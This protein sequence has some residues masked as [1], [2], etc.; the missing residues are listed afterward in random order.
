MCIVGQQ[1]VPLA[2]CLKD[3]LDVP[4]GPWLAIQFGSPSLQIANMFVAT[5][6]AHMFW[7]CHPSAVQ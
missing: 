2:R 5:G 1:A 4:W 7:T 3:S 6:T